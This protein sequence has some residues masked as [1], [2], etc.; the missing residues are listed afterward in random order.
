M[1]VPTGV[2]TA[3]THLV[4]GVASFLL[5]LVFTAVL[6]FGLGSDLPLG[7]VVVVGLVAGGVLEEQVVR[8]VTRA[9]ALTEAELQVLSALPV[10]EERRR[11]LVC[12]R[13]AGVV[14]PVVIMGKFTVVSAALVEALYRGWV[15]VP[16]M[17]ALLVHA[18]G[19]HQLAAPRRGEVAMVVVETPWRLVAA[20]LRGARRAFAW[21]PLGSLAWEWRGVVGVVCLVQSVAEGRTW[22]GVLGA[23][24]IA[25][26]YLMPAAGRAVE[27]RAT[28]AGDAAV[29]Q[30]G[31]GD[32]L[33]D[34]LSRSGHKLSL[35]RRLRL[36]VRTISGA[37][38]SAGPEAP[39]R[40]LHVVRS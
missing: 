15:S 16:E 24:V 28:A 38:P 17:S 31:L 14:A 29:V 32:V 21:M 7:L 30:A 18:R 34:V 27:A 20:V 36:Q 13:T 1:R 19:H 10:M 26:T 2:L 9:G 8:L 35:G 4:A 3:A 23:A 40:H 25:L 11:V 5:A 6:P 37:A 33:V 39:A 12:R 22:S